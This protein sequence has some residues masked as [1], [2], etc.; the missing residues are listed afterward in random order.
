[1]FILKS[2]NSVSP[3]TSPEKFINELIQQL[4]LDK[5]DSRF[6]RDSFLNVM[7]KYFIFGSESNP[8]DSH[9][10]STRDLHMSFITINQEPALQILLKTPR[11]V[12]HYSLITGEIINLNTGSRNSEIPSPGITNITKETYNGMRLRKV[13]KAM[14]KASSPVGA[15][16]IL[17]EFL[18]HDTEFNVNFKHNNAKVKCAFNYVDGIISGAFNITDTRTDVTLVN[19]DFHLTRDSIDVVWGSL[20]SLLKK[21]G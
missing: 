11:E 14:G 13:I 16:D 21:I 10:F 15:F 4:E 12:I 5:H 1:M 6:I 3:T 20:E 9:V 8:Y 7:K 18:E 17:C 2:I 19:M